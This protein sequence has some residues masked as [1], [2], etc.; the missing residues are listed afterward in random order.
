MNL[1]GKFFGMSAHMRLAV[2][3]APLLLVGGYIVADFI[4]EKTQ[5]N[6]RVFPLELAEVC[7]LQTST[8]QFGV[9]DFI[10]RLSAQESGAGTRLTLTT[11]EAVKAVN[12]EML[13]SGG[14]M[15]PTAM[16]PDA[17]DVNLWHLDSTLPLRAIYEVHMV[18]S[19]GK[20]FRM[21]EARW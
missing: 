20:A 14:T 18:V 1:L 9:A 12:L 15:Q 6:E 17:N 8:C 16:T 10:V 5:A 3:I 13:A 11:S 4:E 7:N 2:M 21:G 19:T